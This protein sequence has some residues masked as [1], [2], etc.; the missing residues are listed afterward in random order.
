M[1]F[2]IILAATL[3][4]ASGAAQSQAQAQGFADK[5]FDQMIAQDLGL[6][7]QQRRPLHT[8]DLFFN[9]N[10]D[11]AARSRA[12]F[13]G[14][15][16]PLDARKQAFIFAFASSSTGNGKYAGLYRR[17]YLFQSGGKDFW[18][19]VQD[20]VASYFAKELKTGQ[21]VTL[22]LRNAGG[23]RLEKAWEWVFLV[24]EFSGPRGSEGRQEA[25]PSGPA[26]P[27]APVIPP[28]PKSSV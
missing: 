28:G 21:P 20:Q 26:K 24:E 11:D 17:E 1:R 8:G 9:P 19:P 6:I 7:Q 3:G 13:A 15:S 27:R 2:S 16:R 25:P 12:V 18:L 22:Y 23:M 10:V 14:P 5:S 4:L